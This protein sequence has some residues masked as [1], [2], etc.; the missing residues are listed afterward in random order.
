MPSVQ[1]TMLGARRL[2]LRIALG[3]DHSLS[4]GGGGGQRN[5]N[6]PPQKKK[7]KKKN[8]NNKRLYS[9]LMISL[10]GN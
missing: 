8:N 2:R 4:P 3:T 5:Q 9:V 10:F 1:N 6:P 7:K